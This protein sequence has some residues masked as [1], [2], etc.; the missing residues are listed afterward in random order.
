MQV[1][2]VRAPRALV[3]AAGTM[4]LGACASGMQSS[5]ASMD[6]WSDARVVTVVHT[7][8]NGEIEQGR[9][10][11]QRGGDAR[12]KQF[13]QR[14]VDDHTNANQ[15]I[16]AIVPASALVSDAT[17][18]QLET[19]SRTSVTNLSTASG[20]VFDRAYMEHQVAMHRWTLNGLDQVLIPGADSE[21][22]RTRLQ[23]IRTS[24]AAHLQ[25]A[26]QIVAALR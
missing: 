1:S 20:I 18:T 11:A 16:L 15:Q 8:N 4:V 22:L 25:E 17:A 26:E 19:N 12:V 14:M 5:R 7:A 21:Q 13:G 10:A 9:L 23:T 24:V 6:G 3:F 2:Y